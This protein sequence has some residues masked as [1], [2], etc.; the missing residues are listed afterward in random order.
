MDQ[1]SSILS[2]KREKFRTVIRKE[3]IEQQLKK[4]RIIIPE[5]EDH[6]LNDKLKIIKKQMIAIHEN[7]ENDFKKAMIKYYDYLV[8]QDLMNELLLQFEL[9]W[10]QNY[11]INIYWILC[12]LTLGDNIGAKFLFDTNF[13]FLKILYTDIKNPAYNEFVLEIIQNLLADDD[14]DVFEYLMRDDELLQMLNKN[15]NI[16]SEENYKKLLV[17]ICVKIVEFKSLLSN[18]L[19]E[20]L[21][22]LMPQYIAFQCTYILT[23]R[24]EFSNHHLVLHAIRYLLNNDDNLTS[25]ILRILQEIT[26]SYLLYQI[27]QQ[28]E[29]HSFICNLFLTTNNS[30][31]IKSL[32]TIFYNVVESEEIQFYICQKEVLNLIIKYSLNL[33]YTEK[34]LNVLEYLMQD[35]NFLFEYPELVDEKYYCSQLHNLNDEDPN[36]SIAILNYIKRV[37]EFWDTRNDDKYLNIFSKY[38]NKKICICLKIKVYQIQQISYFY[39]MIELLLFLLIYKYFGMFRTLDDLKKGEK[40][41][42][43]KKTSNSYAGGEKSGLSVENPDDMDQIINNAKQGGTRPDQDEDPKEWCKI[44][45]WSNGFQI[46]DGEFKDI[47]DPENKKFLAELRQNQV[48]T[49]LRSKYPKGLSVKLEDKKT[50]KYV[51]PP[52]PKYVEFSGSGVSL[53]QQQFVQQQ[54]Q[55]KVDLSKQGQIQID[56]N[57]PTTN[58]MVRLSTGNTITLTVNTTTRVSA[59]Q[60]HLLRMMNLPPQKQ[61]QLIS[62]FPPRPIQNLNQTVEEADL[63]D[64]QI[65]QTV[66]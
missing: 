53:G 57:Q 35:D 34:S 51:P 52:P 41:E 30:N 36:T 46:N 12:N 38:K 22:Q 50:E 23:S 31:C 25:I 7:I 4:K 33:E 17:H 48:P 37:L 11:R 43:Q 44:T 15:V 29:I 60:Q 56:P 59:I 28:K 47:N 54:Q 63:C 40:D 45:L 62:G 55:V 32:L 39:A 14:I 6:D 1:S 8:D 16:I 58:I 19:V 66:V 10:Q 26:D 65:T 49:S 20:T 13:D 42:K 2:I 3:F 64:S 27:L 5:Q 24:M 18:Y 9:N 21:C 61:I